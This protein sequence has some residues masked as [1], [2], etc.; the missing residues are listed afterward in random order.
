MDSRG[1]LMRRAAIRRAESKDVT[2]MASAI[3]KAKAFLATVAHKS[4]MAEQ[5]DDDGNDTALY[6]SA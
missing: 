5:E 2:T 4:D 3:K 6:H 1:F